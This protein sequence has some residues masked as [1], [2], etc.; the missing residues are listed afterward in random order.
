M[1]VRVRFAPSPTGSMHLGNVRAALINYLFARQKEGS[2]ILRIEDTDPQRNIEHGK[3]RILQDLAWLALQH[4]EGPDIG[5]SYGPYLQS[6]RSSFYQE[7]LQK[8]VEKQVAYRCFCSAE[9]L[10]KKRQRQIALKKAPRYDRTCAQLS[11]S[12]IQQKLDTQESF[13]WRL[14]LPEREIGVTDLARGE[15]T[16]NLKNFSDCPLTR[17]DGSFTFVFANFVDDVTMEISHV[18]RGEEHIS[19]TA[20]Q[21]ALYGF[22]DRSVPIF[23]HFPIICNSD[24]K[25]LS[26]RDF[27]F[28]L[29]DLRNAGF[30]PEAIVNYLAIIGGSFEQEIMSLSELVAALDFEKNAS[31]GFIR[32]DVEKLRWINHRWLEKLPITEVVQRGRSF[33]EAKYPAASKLDNE[34]LAKLISPIQGELVTLEDLPRMLGFAFEAP[35]IAEEAIA[36]IQQDREKNTYLQVLAAEVAQE[37]SWTAETL[38]TRITKTGTEKGLS[39]KELFQLVRTALTGHPQGIGIKDLL[40]MIGADTASSRIQTLAQIIRSR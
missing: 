5:G 7:Y 8:L 10:E 37:T 1:R 33:L 26:K 38:F 15:L 18:F 25:K 22:F 35:Q 31:A 29:Q 34:M 24:G 3:E 28:S 4:D 13:I 6:E 16:F 23:W 21:A 2:F 9:E 32:Y 12:V 14:L 36:T 11:E 17:Q 27:G 39:N 19:N 40:G 30:L 20:V